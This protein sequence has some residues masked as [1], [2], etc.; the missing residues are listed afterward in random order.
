MRPVLL[1]LTLLPTIPAATAPANAECSRL[2]PSAAPAAARTIGLFVDERLPRAAVKRAVRAWATCPSYGHGFP[3]F[4]VGLGGTR[5]LFVEFDP[6]A[7]GPDE[8]CGNFAGRTITLFA[9]TRTYGGSVVA[10]GALGQN[11]MHELGHA[12]GLADAP[13]SCDSFA[14]AKLNPRNVFHR[15][16]QPVEC[17]LVED[18]WRPLAIR[19]TGAGAASEVTLVAVDDD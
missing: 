1:V 4:E 7:I 17:R 10:C 18:R 5:S 15:R 6:A 13:P 9:R 12:L 11:L 14:M 8:Q 3:S 16:V 2:R 19:R